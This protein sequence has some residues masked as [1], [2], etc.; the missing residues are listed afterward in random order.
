MFPS[1]KKRRKL[2]SMIMLFDEKL[3]SALHIDEDLFT[4]KNSAV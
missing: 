2:S 1:I 4:G 3:T